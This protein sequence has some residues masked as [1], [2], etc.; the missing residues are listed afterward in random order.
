MTNMAFNKKL[1]RTLKMT[2]TAIAIAVIKPIWKKI[3]L[4]NLNK[5]NSINFIFFDK[6]T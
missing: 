1:N 2:V 6:F 3:I 5:K 4:I